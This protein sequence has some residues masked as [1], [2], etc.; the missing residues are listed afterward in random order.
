[1]GC[2]G[3]DL[4]EY[5]LVGCTRAGGQGL[6]PRQAV[7]THRLVRSVSS[8]VERHFL[9]PTCLPCSVSSP[10]GA[11][12]TGHFVLR[13]AQWLRYCNVLGEAVNKPGC[14]VQRGVDV[15]IVGPRIVDLEG[16]VTTHHSI[17]GSCA[18]VHTH[19]WLAVV[20]QADCEPA[21]GKAVGALPLSLPG[22][23][24]GRGLQ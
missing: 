18:H 21:V 5:Q 22:P 24:V 7:Q 15:A 4:L 16:R 1:M 14:G 17:G 23:Y 12:S 9:M 8:D 6:F 13:L 2:V 10:Q 20:G 3:V 11:A 19:A